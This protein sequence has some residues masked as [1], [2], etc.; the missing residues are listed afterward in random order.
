MYIFFCRN[1]HILL[2]LVQTVGRQLIEQRQYKSSQLRTVPPA[3]KLP[4][5]SDTGTNL[6]IIRA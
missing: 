6:Y 2:F 1:E 5:A 4:T 3:R